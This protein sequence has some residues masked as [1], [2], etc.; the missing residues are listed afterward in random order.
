MTSCEQRPNPLAAAEVRIIVLSALVNGSYLE[1][2]HERFDHA[3]RKISIQD[4][5]FGLEQPWKRCSVDRFSEEHWQWKYKIRT[6]DIEGEPLN[7]IIAL[8]PRNKW[9][10]IVT[11]FHERP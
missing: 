10:E 3:E 7:I 4:V 1:R 6:V 2:F 9:F 11:R 5:I 8:D